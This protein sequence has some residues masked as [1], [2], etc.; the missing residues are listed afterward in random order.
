MKTTVITVVSG[1][2]FKNAEL[3]YTQNGT[4]VVRFS[5]PVAAG[6]GDNKHTIW[7]NISWFGKHAEKRLE[8]M[9]KGTELTVTAKGGDIS[10]NGDSLFFTAVDVTIRKYG[11]VDL[12]ATDTVPE[13]TGFDADDKTPF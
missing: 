2:L 13:F 9:T 6:W 11:T 5:F 10:P 12:D 7:Y 4:G 1:T 3:K 8:K